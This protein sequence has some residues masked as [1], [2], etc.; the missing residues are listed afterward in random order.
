MLQ[1]ANQQQEIAQQGNFSRE[2][3]SRRVVERF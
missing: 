3:T 2:G 1:L